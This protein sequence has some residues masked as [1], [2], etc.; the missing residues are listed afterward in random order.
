MFPL[1]NTVVTSAG[2]NALSKTPK[3]SVYPS[4]VA[5]LA[6]DPALFLTAMQFPYAVAKVDEVLL[7]TEYVSSTPLQYN[8]KP[9]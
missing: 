6:P 1:L 9:V 5:E 4:K 3:L 8:F 7:F 2:V